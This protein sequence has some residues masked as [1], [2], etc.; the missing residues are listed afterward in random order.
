M[1]NAALMLGVIAGIW[2]MIVGFFG[3][4]YTE[5]IAWFGEIPDVARQ[6]EN[7]E[8]V[9]AVSLIAPV[10]AVAGGAMARS[11]NVIAG[12][13]LLV[14]AAGMYWGF[15]FGVFTMFP[16]AMAGLGGLLALAARQPDEA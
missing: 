8:R 9:R 4:G 1:R 15:G 2:G 13:L 16:I 10:L 7:V 12:A 5:F 3:Y 14:S 6:V 11:R